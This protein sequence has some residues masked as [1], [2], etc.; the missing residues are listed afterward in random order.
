M[1]AFTGFAPKPEKKPSDFKESTANGISINRMISGVLMMLI[2]F[3]E[4]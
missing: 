3:P 2:I 4:I 1:M